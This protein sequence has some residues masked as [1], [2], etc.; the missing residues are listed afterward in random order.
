LFSEGVA[1]TCS[2]GGSQSLN[3]GNSFTSTIAIASLAAAT[4][5]IGIEANNS[6]DP[7]FSLTF[8]TLVDGTTPEPSTFVLLSV[9]LGVVSVFR[10]TRARQVGRKSR[11]LFTH[12]D[13]GI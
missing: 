13:P 10:L 5:C 3:S 8:N 4:Y 1:G 2:G 9:G 6:N 11:F 12:F 7:A